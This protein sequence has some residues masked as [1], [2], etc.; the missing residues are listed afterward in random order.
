M[1]EKRK[2]VKWASSIILNTEAV[3]WRCSVKKLFLKIS[4]NS[5]ENTCARVSFLLKLQTEACNFIK[6]ET[7]V[8]VFS[9]EFCEIFKNTFLYRIPPVAFSLNKYQKTTVKNKINC[10]LKNYVASLFTFFEK[11]CAIWMRI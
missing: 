11:L 3:T 2:K 10:Y 1:K 8:Q 7:L 9:C 6:T 5:Q 4:P